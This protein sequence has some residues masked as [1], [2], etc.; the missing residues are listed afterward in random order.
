[1]TVFNES[2]HPRNHPTGRS[3][4]SERAQSAPEALLDPSDMTLEQIADELATTSHEREFYLGKSAVKQLVLAQFPTATE[5]EVENSAEGDGGMWI[6]PTVI[7]DADGATLWDADD[8]NDYGFF[9]ELS[10]LTL[11]LDR[12]GKSALFQPGTAA[13]PQPWLGLT[14]DPGEPEPDYKLEALML[15][16]TAATALTI[17][18]A[19]GQSL[20]FSHSA[21]KAEDVDN[22]V[23]ALGRAT[24]KRVTTVGSE[25][26]ARE[27][28]ELIGSAD[29]GILYIPASTE[30]PPRILDMLRQPL[31]EKLL[32]TSRGGHTTVMPADIQLVLGAELGQERK[33]SG[34]ILDRV[35]VRTRIPDGASALE[36]PFAVL[37][38]GIDGAEKARSKRLAGTPYE[39]TRN[40][41]IPGDYLRGSVM[42][43]SAQATAPIDRALERGGITMRGYDRM[44]RAAWTLADIDGSP[45][46][47]AEHIDKA[48][49]LR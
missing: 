27:F 28:L 13:D 2:E 12:L 9:D 43:P 40:S 33:Y 1:M 29:G 8:D 19:G 31:I 49:T 7:R 25:V 20:L 18:A 21:D 41:D 44:I 10:D 26:T 38:E 47:T 39:S 48:M 6:T 36:L 42:R 22:A 45:R 14:I 35:G 24:G 30:L 11:L 3:R 17:A 5:I 37:R 34:P 32:I 23:D 16:D 15:G 46:P 4:F